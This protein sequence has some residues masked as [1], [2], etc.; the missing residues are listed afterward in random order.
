MGRRLLL[1]LLLSLLLPP[2]QGL[3]LADQA[4]VRDAA[5]PVV[6][7]GAAGAFD[8]T[9]LFAPI[10]MEEEGIFSMYYCGSTNDVANRVFKMGLATSTDGVH[11][12]KRPEPVFEFGDGRHSVLTPTLLRAT[13]GTVLREEGKLR[14][15]FAAT[16][17]TSGDGVHTLH[18]STSEDGIQ[19]SAPSPAQLEGV[20]AP[21]VI[22]EG[23]V[24]HM[25]YS[26]VSAEPWVVR[27]AK[28]RDG[29]TWEKTE[30]PCLVVDQ[31]WEKGRLFYPAVLKHEGRYVMWYGA[32]WTAREN[33]TAIG[34][35][36]SEDGVTWVK[37]PGNPV[38]RP[39]ESRPWESHYTTSQSVLKLSDGSWRM[40]YASRKAPPFEN[41]YFAV[42]TARWEGPKVE[43]GE[44]P[45][46]AA[47]LREKMAQALT[48]PATR[49]PLE[50]QTLKATLSEGYRIESVTYGSEPGSRVT[51]LLYLPVASAPAP[52]I[53]VAGGHGGSKSALYAQYAGQ[54]YAKHG[55]AVLAVD[56][57]GEEERHPERK[58]GARGHDLY[59]LPKEE[60]GPFMVEKMKRSILGKIVWDLSRGVD[61]LQSRPEVDGARIGVVGYS[62]GGA[63]AGALAMVD[64]RIKSAIIAGW[65]FTQLGVEWGKAC[66]QVPYEDFSEMMGFGEM[67]ALV[68]PHAS[69][70]I[71][72]G[73][74]DSVIDHREN[75][76]VL[77]RDTLRHVD[78]AWALLK[79]AGV[80][81]RI[82]SAWVEGA[83]HRPYFLTPRALA[84]MDE[85][86]AGRTPNLRVPAIRYGDWVASQGQEIEKLYNTEARELGTMVVKVDA[87]YREPASLACLPVETPPSAEYT[88]EGWVESCVKAAR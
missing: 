7:L 46:R 55:Y 15:W 26:D 3:D 50:A 82:E 4:W 33:T 41:K 87:V 23:M 11:F 39:D 53:V 32:Y 36:T 48:L 13:N 30:A 66:T 68:A 79:A 75:G 24:Y 5:G 59:H 37:S 71:F 10:V 42:G 19:W 86:L 54:L 81:F 44:W 74:E 1:L 28:S 17:F 52:A 2:A 73:A 27:H 34:V 63:S 45:A 67:T 18:E 35:A 70:L 77:R 64:E 20:Y 43:A 38:M 88:F 9:H 80:D 84:W 60:R 69:L 40:W 47:T 51:A 31:P 76:A 57:I 85:T 29:K 12:D 56:T 65:G 25:W 83:C 72:N 62:L 78:E 58:L 22:R 49:G 21:T 8:D 14:L 6:S 61:F 16:D